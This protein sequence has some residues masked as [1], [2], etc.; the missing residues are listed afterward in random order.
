MKGV[1]ILGCT[2]SIG[3]QALDVLAQQKEY[4]EVVALAAGHG[5]ELLRKQIMA[6]QPKLVSVAGEQEAR[7]LR[8]NLPS[9]CNLEI[10]WGLEGLNAVATHSSAQVVLTAITGT[11]G[12]A[13]TVAAIQAGKDIA[14]ANKETLVAAGA[15]VMPLAEKQGVSILP[16]DS[17][18]SAIWQCLERRNPKT[19]GKQN[20]K[21]DFSK[22]PGMESQE[23]GQI[24]LTASGGPFRQEPQDLS[25]V[26]LDMALAHPNW[27]M[28]QKITID[29]ATLMNKG[30]EVIEA[31]WLFG[32][33][34]AK[35]KVVVHPQSIIHSM[36]EFVD[37]S[38]LAQL[39]LPDMRL[40]I[41]FALGY[42]GR[43][44][45]ERLPRID[46]QS[47]QPLTFEP[48]DNK[49]FP[50]LALAYEAGKAGGTMAVV[51]NAANE[52][53][54][55]AFLAEQIG[56]MAIPDIVSQVLAK[57][58]SIANPSLE[59]I[60]AVDLESRRIA[61]SYIASKA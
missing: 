51:L 22:V 7:L 18:H 36:V 11:L 48:P 5:W 52:V 31:H 47:L 39:G 43:L 38:V 2:G 55:Q 10:L 17:E 41:Q 26:T 37:G 44:P 53:A 50:L 59:D 45:N 14:L 58:H 56:F 29:S 46:W 19:R 9:G 25:A 27:Q 28:G 6:F 35:I 21:E 34:Y 33:D 40:P 54:V 4:F 60:L 16:V 20:G 3:C 30:L 23:V 24:I 1:A 42:P 61:A 49:R 13:P 8:Q 15:Y 12:L 32:M 57:H